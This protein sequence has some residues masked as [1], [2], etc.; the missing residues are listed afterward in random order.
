MSDFALREFATPAEARYLDALSKHGTQRKAADALGV[1]VRN[2]QR[3]LKSLKDRAAKQGYSPQHD[4][5]HPVPDGFKLKGTSTLYNESGQL[6][7]QWVKSEADRER[8]EALMRE[9][10]AALSSHIKPEKPV[11]QRTARNDGDLL[12]LYPIADYHLGMLSWAEETGADWDTNI[13]EDLLFSWFSEAIERSPGA[14]VGLLCILG[15]FS[16]W[17]GLDAVTP[18]HHNLL[19]ADT[20]FA[21]L[22]RITIRVLRR[23]V[24]MLLEKHDKLHIVIAEGNHDPASSVWLREWF[25]ALYENEPRVTVDQSPDP[26][27]CYEFGETSLFFHHGH[28]RKPESIADVFAA[29]FRD[30]FGRSKHSY[31]HL[32]HKHETKL[33][34]TPLMVIEQHRTLAAPDAYATRGGWLSGRGASV[35]TYSKDHGEVG[36]V[37]IGPEMCG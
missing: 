21:K 15:D 32:G 4:M 27:Y 7:A 16:H 13:A 37:T 31:A 29:K 19:D 9:V 30:V 12:N 28:K 33:V 25:A 18:E 26:Y 6:T 3:G 24:R 35:V 5:T 20:R 1:N 17:D 36:R 8:Q 14:A 11:R 10:V 22:V 23:V 34:E 2:L